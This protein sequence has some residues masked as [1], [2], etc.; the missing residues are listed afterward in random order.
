MA[1]VGNVRFNASSEATLVDR[2]KKP[3]PS[4]SMDERERFIRSKYERRAWA[5]APSKASL[6]RACLDLDV[7]PES[8]PAG[9]LPGI[10]ALAE[11]GSGAC[12][13]CAYS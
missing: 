4:A 1:A 10:G 11:E 7:A 3:R 2:S 5:G 12:G 6:L 9:Y 8:L 13:R